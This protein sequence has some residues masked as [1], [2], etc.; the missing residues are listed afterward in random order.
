MTT[1]LVPI[2]KFFLSDVPLVP[3]PKDA[4]EADDSDLPQDEAFTLLIQADKL[5]LFHT[6]KKVSVCFLE[7]TLSIEKLSVKIDTKEL[8]IKKNVMI[9]S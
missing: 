5:G 3:V 8:S 1:T 4:L 2:T 6:N 9:Y 7:G